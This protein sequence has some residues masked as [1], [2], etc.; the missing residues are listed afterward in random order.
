MQPKVPGNDPA[1]KGGEWSAY[2][3][4]SAVMKAI[5]ER[6][7]S[8]AETQTNE[9][10]AG[11]KPLPP[12]LREKLLARGIKVDA[13]KVDVVVRNDTKAAPVA[14]GAGAETTS[15]LPEG[16]AEAVDDR[17]GTKYYY[18]SE[19]G[20]SS[21]DRPK[22]V[23]KSTT[24]DE[25][26]PTAPS[27]PPGWR[28][29]VDLQ[30]GR[31]YYCNP[32]TKESSWEKPIDAA[33]VAK[34][35]RCEGCGGFGR[36]LVKAHGFCSHCSRILNK[37]PPGTPS[38]P[39]PSKTISIAGTESRAD[40]LHGHV[41]ARGPTNYAEPGVQARGGAGQAEIGVGL[42]PRVTSLPLTAVSHSMQRP[43]QRLSQ[44]QRQASAST[45]GALDPM[46]P[47]SYS[48]APHGKWGSGLSGNQ[49]RAGDTTAGGS[50]YQSRPYPAPGSVLRQNAEEIARAQKSG[51]G[52][53][54]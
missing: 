52:E 48:D 8:L 11:T 33:V 47:S 40:V 4:P 28:E 38:A 44:N 12:F 24:T 51:L 10:Q 42:K 22:H 21:W 2:Q 6:T 34:M 45:G 27:L 7:S 32:F 14:K 41:I 19:L 20:Q 36:G 35:K 46:D 37:P 43:R 53:A 5:K 49:P 54:D 23:Q 16:W 31:T 13:V 18:N 30:S 26:E 9:Q 1:V 25:R 29:S 3:P 50:L 17:Y 15:I 39:E